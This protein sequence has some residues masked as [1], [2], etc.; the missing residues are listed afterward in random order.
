ML[1]AFFLVLC[2]ICCRL[3]R[4]TACRAVAPAGSCCIML[5]AWTCAPPASAFSCCCYFSCD[6]TPWPAATGWFNCAYSRA[7]VRAC[8]RCSTCVTSARDNALPPPTTP[9]RN[10]PP[11]CAPPRSV[12]APFCCSCLL[13]NILCLFLRIHCLAIP[14]SGTLLPAMVGIYRRCDIA[15]LPHLSFWDG[16]LPPNRF[17]GL[18][19]LPFCLRRIYRITDCAPAGFLS[20]FFCLTLPWRVHT[21]AH[22]C[23][24]GALSPPVPAYR[25]RSIIQQHSRLSLRMGSAAFRTSPATA[26]PTCAITRA[27]QLVCYRATLRLAHARTR[28]PAPR[29]AA[30][31]TARCRAGVPAVTCRAP[32]T[33]RLPR[34]PP[35][36]AAPARSRYLR[37]AHLPFLSPDTA[38]PATLLLARRATITP[39][40]CCSFCRVILFAN[41][42]TP[43]CHAPS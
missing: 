39:F 16:G 43:P 19:D 24:R 25:Q 14:L 20:H 10:A 1:S 7:S 42:G 13:R 34:L 15:D 28:A 3:S 21:F 30:F 36:H 41:F 31:C 9:R 4:S 27:P 23:L 37:L 32:G 38:L 8:C 11:R 18:L 35:F 33:A 5:A 26:L 29:R 22:S 12:S 40:T 17:C 6:T 2:V